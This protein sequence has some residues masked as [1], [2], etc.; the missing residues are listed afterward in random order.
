MLSRPLPDAPG[1]TVRPIAPGDKDALLDLFESL[2]P[3]SRMRRFLVPKPQLSGRE[4][5]YFTEVDHRRHE[6]LVVEGPDGALVAVARYAC[7]FTDDEANIA[8]V[9]FAVADEW[10][11]RGIGRTLA[12]LLVDEARRNGI[13]A[14][15]ATTLHHNRPARRL[16]I[17]AGFELVGI[18]GGTLELA[19]D[20]TAP[21]A[22][23][24]RRAA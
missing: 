3:D 23:G 2:S 9:A 8:E 12:A 10:Q 14:L 11:G 17:R 7:G 20:L 5:A 13:A 15:R 18:D 24:E 6:A 4:L 16:L 21:D 19:L 22:A 1:L